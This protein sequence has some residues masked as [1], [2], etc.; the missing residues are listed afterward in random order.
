MAGGADGGVRHA[1]RR[2][3]QRR[4]A[5][6]VPN[7]PICLRWLLAF[8][9]LVGCCAPPPRAIR[10]SGVNLRQRRRRLHR[11]V[12]DLVE[13]LGL[14]D[15]EFAHILEAGQPSRGDAGLM[16]RLHEPPQERLASLIGLDKRDDAPALQKDVVPRGPE[17][18]GAGS[19]KRRPSPKPKRMA[20]ALAFDEEKRIAALLQAIETVK[21]DAVALPL[22]PDQLGAPIAGHPIANAQETAIGA[23]VGNGERL[24]V[25]PVGVLNG[26][27]AKR[28]QE[29]DGQMFQRRV[30]LK[31]EP[32]FD[33]RLDAK[34]LR[35]RKRRL[36][37][38]CAIEEGFQ[39]QKIA[40]GVS[41]R[42]VAPDAA[43]RIDLEGARMS[44]GACRIFGDIFVALPASA[45]EPA[46]QKRPR[47]QKR[48]PGDL[49][50]VQR[51]RL[52]FGAEALVPECHWTLPS[53]VFA[54]RGGTF[55]FCLMSRI[56]APL[57]SRPV[58][59]VGM[60]GAVGAARFG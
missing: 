15:M 30:G 1:K 47:R 40:P 13:A 24:L 34:L 32:L 44:V 26:L 31:A 7:Q 37:Q 19:A 27:K 45:G 36:G 43:S 38:R 54:S 9:V 49:F 2:L 56:Q 21:R 51:R 8:F 12:E 6:G 50:E 11:G 33:T 10:K 25:W 41:C 58:G 28:L 35:D 53:K 16:A 17:S 55:F 46:R 48:C 18:G 59:D 29:R 3:E 20:I 22:I 5:F 39:I 52:D 42:E 23:L 57:S 60:E 4:L 14:A